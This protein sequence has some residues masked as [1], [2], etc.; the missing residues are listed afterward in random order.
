MV[1]YIFI[2]KGEL[3]VYGWLIV[4]LGF[5]YYSVVSESVCSVLR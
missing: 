1:F 5:I 3:V 2:C 4:R